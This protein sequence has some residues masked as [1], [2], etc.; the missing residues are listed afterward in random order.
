MSEWKDMARLMKYAWQFG[1][2]SLQ[3]CLTTELKIK[4]LRCLSDVWTD[5]KRKI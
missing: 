2:K 1:K 4:P 3:N 5:L